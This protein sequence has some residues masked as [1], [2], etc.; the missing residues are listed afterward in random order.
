M[1]GREPARKGHVTKTG[2]PA[3]KRPRGIIRAVRTGGRSGYC[4]NVLGDTIIGSRSHL[5]LDKATQL[6][7]AS[8]WVVSIIP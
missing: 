2:P 7:Q 5:G 4:A 6:L 1:T 8:I 3:S